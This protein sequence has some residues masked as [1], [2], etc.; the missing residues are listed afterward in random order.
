M[1]SRKLFVKLDDTGS[2]IQ[3][4]T[5]PGSW[6]AEMGEVDLTS[7]KA[8]KAL[9]IQGLQFITKDKVVLEIHAEDSGSNNPGSL[10]VVIMNLFL[11]IKFRG[12]RSMDGRCY[13]NF[14]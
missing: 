6:T 14:R 2:V 8:V 4:K 7:V 1:S 11:I 9:G 5:E 12:E 13:R 3:W 10:L